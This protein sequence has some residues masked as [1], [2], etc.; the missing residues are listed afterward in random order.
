MTN[1]FV[2]GSLTEQPGFLLSRVGTAVQSGFKDVLTTWG[3]RPLHFMLLRGIAARAGSSQQELCRAL[4]IDSGNMVELI[5]KLEELGYATRTRSSEDRRRQVL[6]ISRKGRAALARITADVAAFEV[7]F[8][9]PLSHHEL[10]EL[11]TLLARLYV[12]T[13]EGRGK[14]YIGTAPPNEDTQ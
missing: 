1:E 5:D 9:E 7:D 8:F 14:S 2:P 3:M 4:A 10:T 11:G 12:S 13:A 6:K